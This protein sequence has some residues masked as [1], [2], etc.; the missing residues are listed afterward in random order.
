[1][2]ELGSFSISPLWGGLSVWWTIGRGGKCPFVAHK[3]GTI[4]PVKLPYRQ[5]LP[6]A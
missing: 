3:G 2:K 1:M 4:R 6:S 5:T